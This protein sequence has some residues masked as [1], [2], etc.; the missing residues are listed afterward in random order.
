M[1]L[2]CCMTLTARGV[3]E[4]RL[5][6]APQLILA[7]QT[8]SL[9]T[10][11][12]LGVVAYLALEGATTRDKLAELLWD[13]LDFENPK[14][15]LRQELYRLAKTPIADFLEVGDV[16]RLRC[17]CDARS[18]RETD[19]LIAADFM[20]RFE[21]PQ[22]PS[23]QSWLQMQRETFSRLRLSRLES[24][25]K[26]LSGLSALDAWLEVL[27]ADALRETA[28]QAAMRL[29]ATHLGKPAALERYKG[30]KALLKSELSLEPLPETL[31]LA[32]ELGLET[33]AI[34]AP[35]TDVRLVRLLEAASLLTQP[36]EAQML[37][38]VTG[39]TDFEVLE[40]LEIATKKG[41]L[42]RSESGYELLDLNKGM[43]AERKRILERRIAKRFIALSAAPE[44]IAAHLE[45]ADERLEATKKFLEA[46]EQATRQNRIS[47][48]FTFY[49]KVLEL[50]EN[51]EQRFLVLQSK[52]ILA[53]RLDNRI[54]REAIRDLE[55]EARTRTPEHRVTAD[56]QRSLWHL[57]NAEYEKALEF[58][59]PHLE[60]TGKLGAMAAYLQGTVLIKTGQLASAENHLHRALEDK[61][62]LEDQQAAEVHNV[63][64]VLAVQHGQFPI[65]KIHN[66]ASLKGFSRSGQDL[67]LTRALSTAGVLEMLSGQHRAAT[68]MFKRSLEM[69]IK[70]NDT[71][72]QVAT[73]L[74]LSKTTFETQQFEASHAYLEQGLRLLEIQPDPSLAGSY[75]VNIAAIERIQLKLQSAWT[76]VAKA[77]ELAQEQNAM[78]KVSSRA[79]VL[80]DMAIERHQY[81]LAQEYLDLAAQHIT[82]ELEAELILGKAHLALR[83]QQPQKTLDLLETQVFLNSDL[84][85]RSGLMAFAYLQLGQTS[86]AQAVLEISTS[87]VYAPFVQAA[88]IQV[89]AALGISEDQDFI[90][91][92]TKQSLPFIRYALYQAFAEHHPNQQGFRKEVLKLEKILQKSPFDKPE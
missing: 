27:R 68:R 7:G 54:W 46:A 72:G 31:A 78:P 1:P 42:R 15:N 92:P 52:V 18:A 40:V 39:L 43:S 19:A 50:G 5:F 3:L 59:A 21:V 41:L 24:R 60:R 47:D 51:T 17:D 63:L 37:L 6:G 86:K 34:S 66:Q 53:R 85:F 12:A 23:F 22:A 48:A 61:N 44:M 55:R 71:A 69:A 75:L 25:A 32:H 80:A 89:H 70:L 11:R 90:P 4:V 14:R 84:E 20:L 62:A 36:F 57:S 88:R 83:Q 35:Q 26:A 29:E 13:E 8:L 33:K 28:V 2:E 76:R 64:C 82:P 65:A 30:F 58:V 67:G 10:K 45:A 56:L 79:L 77:L 81:S 49:N 74:N 87:S 73:L 9:P 38:D 91:T 16:V